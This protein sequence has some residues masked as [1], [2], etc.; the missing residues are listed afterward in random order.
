MKKVLAFF[1]LL[2]GVGMVACGFYYD[3]V[4]EML[5]V[6]TTKEERKFP[7]FI[8]CT[9]EE[10]NFEA[11]LIANE[12]SIMYFNTRGLLTNIDDEAVLSPI[13]NSVESREKLSRY[14]TKMDDLLNSFY[15]FKGFEEKHSNEENKIQYSMKFNLKTYSNKE[16]KKEDE[17]TQT[18]NTEAP[19]A[20]EPAVTTDEEGN[21]VIDFTSMDK[22]GN[23]KFSYGDKYKEVKEQREKEG[24]TCN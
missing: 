17:N 10:K 9:K 21:A 5:G 14:Y 12:K 15:K 8:T 11:E 24:F 3:E 7:E 22:E 16:D 18:E 23:T 4:L 20:A 19:E 2:L 13:D 1:L 6:S